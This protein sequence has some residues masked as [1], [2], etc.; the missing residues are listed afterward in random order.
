MS[1]E[2]ESAPVS[3]TSEVA[4][5]VISDA[6][7]TE[8][9]P[10]EVSV[11]MHRADDG[12]TPNP[13][14]IL[15]EPTPEPAKAPAVVEPKLSPAMEFLVKQG[16]KAIKEDGRKNWL[17]VSTVEGMLARYADHA[18]VE[19]ANQSKNVAQERDRYKADLDELY[20][21]VQGLEPSEFIKKIGQYDPRYQA[22]L[23]ARQAPPAPVQAPQLAM[24]EPDV[25]LPDGS[26]TYSVQGIQ[27]LIEWAVDAKM[28]P[29]VADRLKPYEDTAKAE[30]ARIEAEKATRA[31]QERARTLMADA[32]QWPGFKEH[33][34]AIL[35]ALREDSAKAKAENRR[36]SL[37]LEA[38]Y[39]QAVLP[40]MTAD[41]NSMREELLKEMSSAAK[42]TPTATRGGGATPKVGPATTRDIASRMI[43]QLEG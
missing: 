9:A 10:A 16:H 19:H 37:S 5:Q 17:P 3:S 36:P 32:Q 39:R 26:T 40:K 31:A 2:V 34:E 41:R 4:E 21:D 8:S 15:K 27:K 14:G 20:K 22:F 23:E 30:K 12:V 7:T 6:E 42:A 18:L 11:E 13:Q 29:K 25:P 1:G 24:P 28:M 43:D 38:A 33:E 35:T